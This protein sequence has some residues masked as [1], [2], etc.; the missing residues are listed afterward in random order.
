MKISKMLIGILLVFY[1]TIFTIS[2]SK[3]VYKTDVLGEVKRTNI[4][5]INEIVGQDTPI[6]NKEEQETLDLI[7]EYRKENGLEELK[8]ILILQNVA[9]LKAEDLVENQYFSHIS[10]KLG[11]PF[12]MLAQN[13]VDYKIA[14]ENLAG[15]IT[16]KKAVNAW[17]NSASHRDNILEED[18][19]YTG[20]CV[21]DSPVYG[22]IFVQLFIGI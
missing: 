18:F 14:G 19:K 17:I 6:L 5:Y 9:R 4:E 10:E 20:I 15:N 12:E 21:I 3:S 22:K 11:T 7:N 16:P 1:V 8:S 2:I 13:D